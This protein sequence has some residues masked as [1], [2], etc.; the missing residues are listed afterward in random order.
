MHYRTEGIVLRTR[1]YG[2]ADLIVTF[3]TYDHGLINAFAKSPR[4]TKS[5]FG[6]SLEPLSH[7]RLSV[8]G[9]ENAALP[10]L[11]QSDIITSFQ[12][13]RESYDCF[14]QVS[15]LIE[16][17]LTCVP[18]KDISFNVFGFLLSALREVSDNCSNPVLFLSLKVKLLKI[19]GFAPKLGSCAR[20]GND[21]HMFYFS[22]GSVFCS[23]CST[24][25]GQ[26]AEL[27]PGTIRLYECLSSW[28]IDKVCRVRTDEKILKELTSVIGSHVKYYISKEKKAR[29][30]HIHV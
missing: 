19:A 24:P 29:T 14:T 27:S 26:V 8:W 4:K 3:L 12:K 21:A 15:E 17:I 16:L 22:E 6:S 7:V 2:E 25:S 30:D 5:R 23:N 28:K 18:E 20:C 1:E 13:I 11:T 9:K 10:R